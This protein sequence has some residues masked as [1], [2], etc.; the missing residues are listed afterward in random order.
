MRMQQVGSFAANPALEVQPSPRVGKPFAH[1]EAQESNSGVLKL[2]PGL[3]RGHLDNARRI[4]LLKYL[5]LSEFTHYN[6]DGP[7]NPYALV[8]DRRRIE[9]AFPSFEVTR[10]YKRF[11][12]APPLP[13]HGLPGQRVMGWHLWAHLKPRGQ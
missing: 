10:T 3:L 8:Y 6:T 11:M 5:R 12:H 9:Q 4:G 13:V 1:L 2:R 7:H